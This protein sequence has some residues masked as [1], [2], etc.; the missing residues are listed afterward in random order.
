[1]G[2]AGSAGVEGVA[3]AAVGVAGA[4]AGVAGAGVSSGIGIS[5]GEAVSTFFVFNSLVCR[6][7]ALMSRAIFDRSPVRTK[8]SGA[9]GGGW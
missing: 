3:G 6:S 8:P 7:S 2:V 9:C 4:A 1:M 5:A